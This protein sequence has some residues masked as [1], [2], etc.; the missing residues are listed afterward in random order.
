[1]DL[2][3]KLLEDEKN[4]L[5]NSIK[6]RDREK[7]KAMKELSQK[8]T[9]KLQGDLSEK[10]VWTRIFPPHSFIELLSYFFLEGK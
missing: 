4:A 2:E 3:K 7:Q 1:M 5:D 6:A 9:F 10:E 8:L